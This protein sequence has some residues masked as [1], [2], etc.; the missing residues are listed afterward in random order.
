MTSPSETNTRSNLPRS[1]CRAI[2]WMTE[3]SLLLV[4]APSWRH[5]AEWLP[6]PRTN[7]PKCISRRA[8]PIGSL[9]VS[10]SPPS[11]ADSDNLPQTSRRDRLASVL[12]GAGGEPFDELLLEDEVE[13]EDGDG[14]EDERRG[15]DRV[16]AVE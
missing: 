5:P 7:T 3:S 9:P 15:E 4:A 11:A 13:G 8:A 2:S 1:A 6:V 12:H 14:E 16:V 10:G